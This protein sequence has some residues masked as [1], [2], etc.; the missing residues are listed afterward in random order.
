MG[1]VP[2]VTLAKLSKS[3]LAEQRW[4]LRAAYSTTAI[5]ATRLP[6]D[7][8]SRFRETTSDAAIMKRAARA[9]YEPWLDAGARIF[10]IWCV[11][12]PRWLSGRVVGERDVVRLFIDGLAVRR[13]RRLAG[14]LEQRGLIAKLGF[15]FLRCRL[16][17]PRQNRQL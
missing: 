8:L 4:L 2:L 13:W 1:L 14:E 6:L 7:A 17:R 5:V 11:R 10:R 3:R 16:S 9:M 12:R 15:G